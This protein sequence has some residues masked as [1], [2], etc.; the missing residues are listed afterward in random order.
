MRFEDFPFSGPVVKQITEG[1]R[2]FELA[3]IFS[4]ACVADILNFGQKSQRS[5]SIGRA[6]IQT[7][8]RITQLYSTFKAAQL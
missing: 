8:I 5:V 3:N 4:F 1:R 6:A 2:N 7:I